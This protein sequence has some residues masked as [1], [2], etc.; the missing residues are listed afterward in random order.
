MLTLMFRSTACMEI[1]L[2]LSLPSLS[3][4]LLACI[5]N[6]SFLF[7]PFQLF[8]NYVYHLHCEIHASQIETCV[9]SKKVFA[10]YGKHP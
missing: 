9:P 7:F 8:A 3:S 2:Y 10:K 5:N 6:L 1:F 4:G